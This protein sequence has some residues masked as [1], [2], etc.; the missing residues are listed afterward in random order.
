M[1]INGYNMDIDIEVIKTNLRLKSY[2]LIGVGSGRAV[3]DLNNGYVVKAA[4]NRKGI[5]Q[6]KAEYQISE[7]NHQNIFAKVAA[8]SEDYRF[9]VME[10]AQRISSFA[11]IWKYYNVKNNRQ[12]FSSDEFRTILVKNDLLTADLYRLS[13][14]GIINGRPVMIDYGFTKRVSKFYGVRL[15]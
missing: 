6:N 12:L 2:P 14:W 7:M 5:E 15:F 9:L 1:H 3:Y 4:K 10:K 8:H 11:E 13:S